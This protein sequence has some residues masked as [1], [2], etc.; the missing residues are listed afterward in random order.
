MSA[1]TKI[2]VL[3][4]KELLYSCIF[5]LLGVL[6]L[7]LVVMLFLPDKGT[8]ESTPDPSVDIEGSEYT[9]GIYSTE[10]VLGN[11]SLEVEVVVDSANISDIRLR[12]TDEAV[13][14]MYPLLQPTFESICSQV[15][16]NQSVEGITYSMDS[17][18][19]SLVLL[20]AIDNS[21]SKALRDKTPDL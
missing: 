7:A 3:H 11:R 9:P 15:L 1:K 6:F 12:N 17:K 19:T 13:T 8:E 2:V 10:L 20:E 18:Y 5:S 14:T 21:L 4:K 16:E